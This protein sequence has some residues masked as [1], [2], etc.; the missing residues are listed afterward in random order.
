MAVILRIINCQ[1]SN[2]TK[3]LFRLG[4]SDINKSALS[5]DR[6]EDKKHNQKKKVHLKFML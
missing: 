4:R 6:L 5:N 3:S 2:L 1:L